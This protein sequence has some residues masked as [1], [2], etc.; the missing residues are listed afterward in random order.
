MMPSDPSRR[1]GRSGPSRDSSRAARTAGYAIRSL[2]TDSGR[3]PTAAQTTRSVARNHRS[4]PGSGKGPPRPYAATDRTNAAGQP[5]GA[6]IAVTATAASP[7]IR[8]ML[9]SDSGRSTSTTLGRPC[10]SMRQPAV[11]RACDARSTPKGDHPSIVPRPRAAVSAR[12]RG[13]V[14][15]R[16]RGRLACTGTWEHRPAAPHRRRMVGDRG[17]DDDPRECPC[18]TPRHDEHRGHPPARTP[19]VPSREVRRWSPQEPGWS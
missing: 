1:A 2:D 16:R 10:H 5:S 13:S 19:A 12:S 15:H 14:R 8:T 17:I 11:D 7:A 4:S 9:S 3:R 6:S 18:T